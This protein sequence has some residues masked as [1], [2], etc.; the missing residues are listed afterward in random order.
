MAEV[1]CCN[2]TDHEI[3]IALLETE[4]ESF[5]RLEQVIQAIEAGGG[6][7]GGTALPTIG[8]LQDRSGTITA[9]GVSQQLAPANA[10]RKYLVVENVSSETLWINFGVAAVQAQPSIKIL[11]NGYFFMENSFV[12]NEAVNIIGATTGSAFTAKESA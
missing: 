1:T 4:N 9:G 10:T 12:S 7:S 2:P 8:A 5:H 11:P 6:G 3:L